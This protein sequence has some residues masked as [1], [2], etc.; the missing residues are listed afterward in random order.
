MLDPTRNLAQTIVTTPP[1]PALSGTILIVEDGDIFPDPAVDGAYNLIIK[2]SDVPATL[3]NS[4]IVR[5]TAK[6]GDSLT[7]S[8]SQESSIARGIA[9]GDDVYLSTT[10]K[11]ID[12]I[13]TALDDYEGRIA[14]NETDLADHEGRITQNENDIVDHEGRITQNENDIN[15]LETDKADKTTEIAAGAGLSGGGDFSDDRTIDFDPNEL[16]AKSTPI[17]ADYLVG[18]DSEDSN[19][20]RKI[21]IQNIIDVFGLQS[22]GLHQN[23]LMNGNFDV[24]QGGTSFT[25]ATTPANND[26]TFLLD[27]WNLISDGNDAVDVSQEAITDLVGSNYALKLD[28]ETAK[29]YGVVQFLEAKDALVLKGQ[30]VS[31]SFYVKSANISALRAAV[32]SWGGTANSVT[33]DIVSAGG[34]GATPTWA[35]NWTAENTPSDLTVTSSWTRVTIE[36]IVLDSSTINNL[37]V[38]IWTPNEETIGDIVYITQVQ[39]NLGTKAIPFRPRSYAEELALCQRYCYVIESVVST[40]LIMVGMGTAATST[41]GRHYLNLP[42][43]MFRQPTLVA[44]ASD[45]ILID[46]QNPGIDC[47]TISIGTNT[48][49]SKTIIF[50]TSVAGGL[51]QYRPYGLATDGNGARKLRLN[52]EL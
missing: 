51:T 31:L 30:T 29:R 46:F 44:T 49:S 12:D 9:S 1:S 43:E 48:S 26:D 45:F 15:D 23:A 24:A 35:A 20:P 37:A 25:S 47:A 32:L 6:T 7:I 2:P 3:T 17:A 10:K 22:V 52:A 16:S 41:V 34:W 38:A 33:S 8:R 14:Q 28:T 36:N 40:D 50:N 42:V 5:V 21:L 4:E 19:S 18:I 13:D 39:L 27:R 11:M